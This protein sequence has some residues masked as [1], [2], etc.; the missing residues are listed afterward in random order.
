MARVIEVQDRSAFREGMKQ[1]L[2]I[3]PKKTVVL[4]VDMQREYLDME[5][6]GSPVLPEEA[7][8]VLKHAK[9]LLTFARQQGIPVVHVYV[10]RRMAEIEAGLVHNAYSKA[11]QQVRLSQLPH[12]PISELL[13]RVEGSPQSQVPVE[14][15]EPS[16]LHVTTKKT[17][18]GYLGSDLDML[19]GRALKPE[20]VVLT[21]INTDTC[22]YATTFST[23]NRGYKP[24]VIS[25]C[26]A[27]MRGK[28]SHQMALELMARSIAWVLT[29]EEFK[30]KVL[31]GA[32]VGVA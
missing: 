5:I 27:S 26:V 32:R 3:D 15:V 20:T 24:V 16:D 6:G 18:D 9:E 29:V 8:R 22:V 30:E 19:L 2:T 12:A 21:G 23:A 1:A 11:G 10:A 7:E 28:D 17:L 31:A 14:L 4:T 25:D 13:D